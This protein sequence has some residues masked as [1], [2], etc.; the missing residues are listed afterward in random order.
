MIRKWF[1][2][3]LYYGFCRKL[4]QSSVP[5]FGSIAKRMRYTCCKHIFFK[6]GKEVN[7]DRNAYFGKGFEV[8]IGDYSGI[9]FNCI[10]PNNIIIGEYVMMAP[11]VFIP[12]LNHNFS[13]LDKPMCF[14]GTQIQ[15]RVEI[16]NDV[17]IGRRAIINPGRI[18]KKG[19]IIAAATVVHKDYAEYSIVGG[20]PSI[21]IGI[22]K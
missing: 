3:V 7:I 2:L 11:E 15:K 5:F 19:T 17:W 22:R 4:P 16:G 14:Q 13:D 21:L 1:F 18:I 9:G 6:C 10:V 20:N 8:R 12:N